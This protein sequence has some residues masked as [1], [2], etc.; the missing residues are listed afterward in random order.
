MQQEQSETIIVGAGLA[1]VSM[2]WDFYFNNIP[3]TLIDGDD[4]STA[5]AA[6]GLMNPVVFRRL[7]QSWRATEFMP[8]AFAF[9]QTIE[10]SLNKRVLH[11][12]KFSRIL[13]NTGE[14]N[15]WMLKTDE[16]PDFFGEIS[17]EEIKGVIAPAGFAHVKSAAYLDLLTFIEESLNYF[18]SKGIKV[19]KELFDYDSISVEKSYVFCEGRGLHQN[20]FF[21]YLPLN[22]THGETLFIKTDA[23]N[24]D[25]VLNK[26]LFILPLGNNTYRIGATYNW[27]EKETVT[28]ETGKA[29]LLEKLHEFTD[30]EF[31]IIDQRAGIR[32]TVID[33]RPLLGQHPIHKN[34][35]VFNGL[36]TKGVML[37][38]FYV[39]QF[40]NYFKHGIEL[41]NMVNINRFLKH[42]REQID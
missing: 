37:A 39:H 5:K 42:F 36:G 16:F 33:R 27:K 11:P 13:S 12:T 4:R 40:T 26:N 19:Q 29:E 24:L 9:Y 21:N 20:P 1:G 10:K 3:F 23:L 28:T 30:F 22:G 8:V 18:K 41:E 31:E 14:V 25:E 15:D 34:L 38:P 7:N 32:P 17:K 35:Y 2:A 6:A